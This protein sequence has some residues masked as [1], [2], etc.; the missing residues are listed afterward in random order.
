MSSILPLLAALLLLLPA[1]AI[2]QRRTVPTR[3]DAGIA[4]VVVI[5]VDQLRPDQLRAYARQFTGGFRRLLD[6][7][8]LYELGQQ[9]HAITETAP[10]H[11]TMLS[12]RTPAHTG[13]VSNEHGVTD[14]LAPV[15]G[16]PRVPGASP[17]NFRGTTLYDWMLAADPATRQLSVSR[18]D[19]SAILMTGR[20]R[21]EVYWY[22]DGAFTTSQYYADTL[23]DWVEA[24]NARRGPQRMAGRSWTLLRADSLYRERDDQP[25]EHGGQDVTFPH[26][27]PADAE[28]TARLFRYYPW[29]DSLTAEFALEG[30]R[31]RGLGRRGRPDLLT[32]SFSTTDAVGHDFGP[33]SR[34]VHDHLLR[35]DRWLGAFLDSLAV[36]VPAERT[37]VALTA[38]HG[39][40]PLPEWS[41]S[42][43]RAKGG[44]VSLG[45]LAHGTGAALARRWRHDFRV[46]FDGGLIS[47]DTGALRARGLDVDSL[48]S[49]IAAQAR[50]R[51]GVRRVYTPASL[52]AAPAS[53]REAM[54]WRNQLPADFQ[55]L[56]CAAIEPGYV[57]SDPGETHAQHGSTAELDVLV[58]ILFMGKDIRAERPRRPARTVDIA[59]TLAAL[60]GIRPT[61]PLDGGVLPEVVRRR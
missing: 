60:L 22:H 24:F 7:S 20:A 48:S 59:P 2:A 43:G 14:P 3:S 41:R 27:L 29:M 37:I 11:S 26:R 1:P 23:P 31:R 6:R 44:R 51:P 25:F 18:K 5:A 32:V 56:I 42:A 47:A 53:D 8:T 13:I 4:L 9:Q 39:V 52:R 50:R 45:D 40:Q 10:G 19:R 15:V 58:P 16:N 34:E 12:G 36:L 49:V 30:V 38:D 17:R 54:L 57:W 55:W 61:E 46:V 35:L 21:G 28:E 33:D